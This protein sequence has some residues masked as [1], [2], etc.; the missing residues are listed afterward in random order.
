MRY[1]KAMGPS[2]RRADKMR[3][4]GNFQSTFYFLRLDHAS[5]NKNE[6]DEKSSKVKGNLMGACEDILNLQ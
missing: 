4:F 1:F 5:T 2:K 6:R 3:R